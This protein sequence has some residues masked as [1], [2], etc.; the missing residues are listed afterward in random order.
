LTPDVVFVPLAL[1]ALASIAY[2]RR[3]LSRHARLAG[4]AGAVFAFA[5]A[6]AHAQRFDLHPLHFK[7]ADGAPM[8]V[9]RVSHGFLLA[10]DGLLSNAERGPLIA[11]IGPEGK[12]W[13]A[14]WD[15]GEGMKINER[16][17]SGGWRA[18]DSFSFVDKEGKPWQGKLVGEEFVLKPL[19]TLSPEIH[20]DC[21]EF[22]MLG[23]HHYRSCS[24]HNGKQIGIFESEDATIKYVSEFSYL[25]WNN[26]PRVAT[27]KGDR[28]LVRDAGGE[29][30]ETS[31]LEMLGW[32]GTKQS[33]V[34][35]PA[36]GQFK[37]S[38]P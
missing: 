27:W 1:P 33:A 37:V 12:P 10:P 20:T 3:A 24:A 14:R 28:F 11:Y 25:D 17:G 19:P 18:S 5:L 32:D 2:C 38:T 8:S 23:D 21:V 15:L 13:I 22:A 29:P 26:A 4:L 7:G 31:S 35:D 9:E 34:W 16:D 6:A 36:A 30:A